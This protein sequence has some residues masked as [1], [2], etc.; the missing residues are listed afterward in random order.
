[1]FRRGTTTKERAPER[2]QPSSDVKQDRPVGEQPGPYSSEARRESPVAA[3][4]RGDGHT[5]REE[6]RIAG[7]EAMMEARPL[8]L[9]GYLANWYSLL[10]GS[11]LVVG[12]IVL[13]LRLFFKLVSADSTNWFVAGIYHIT[14][15][16]IRPFT[17][18]FSIHT[19]T[20]G[21]IF[22]PAVVIAMVLFLIGAVLAIWVVRSLASVR[23]WG[24]GLIW[25]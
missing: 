22:E 17:G 11:A 1:M 18:V 25:R 15:Q 19:V 23:S 9:G 14:G 5:V 3:P 16:M 7:R 6:E 8:G 10:V 21:G 12:E 24:S 13:G 2:T 20:G 4:P